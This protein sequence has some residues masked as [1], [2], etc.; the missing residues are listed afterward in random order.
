M[1]ILDE[2]TGVLAPH[3]LSAFIA[4]LRR[5]KAEGRIV[6]IVTHKLGEAL[7]VADRVTVLRHGRV[8]G[9]RVASATRQANWRAS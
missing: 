7:A 1:L 5:L 8:A 6:I 2:P 4:M 9:E 3:E